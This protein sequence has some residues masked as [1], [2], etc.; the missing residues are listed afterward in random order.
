MLL[1]RGF[2]TRTFTFSQCPVQTGENIYQPTSVSQDAK[3]DIKCKHIQILTVSSYTFSNLF[4][5]QIVPP[6]VW[7]FYSHKILINYNSTE[8][9]GAVFHT[10]QDNRRGYHTLHL[11]NEMSCE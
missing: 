6:S 8:I 11:M 1:L 7:R 10:I 2:S 4:Y 5:M 9:T 3:L